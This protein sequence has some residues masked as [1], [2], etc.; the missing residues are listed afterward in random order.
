MT[1]HNPKPKPT[2]PKQKNTRAGPARTRRF[3]EVDLHSI[4]EDYDYENPDWLV[5]AN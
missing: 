5:G 3:Q 4:D 1:S 2:T